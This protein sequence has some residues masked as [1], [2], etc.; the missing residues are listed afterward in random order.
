MAGIRIILLP[1]G[2]AS[3]T[4]FARLS[5]F[6]RHE[7]SLLLFSFS[8]HRAPTTRTVHV[9]INVQRY[10]SLLESYDDGDI[11]SL[12]STHQDHC[13][14]LLLHLLPPFFSFPLS[15][16][17]SSSRNGVKRF[18]FHGFGTRWNCPFLVYRPIRASFSRRFEGNFD[19]GTN[20]LSNVVEIIVGLKK[21]WEKFWSIEIEV[22]KL[23]R[24]YYYYYYCLSNC[25]FSFIREL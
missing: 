9:T 10:L 22:E 1:L 14:L 13:L 6:R 21:F 18:Q 3:R 16:S 20:L 7:L 4:I 5:T 8:L 25:S 11:V 2:P 23:N 15:L 24:C 19:S 12:P 17:L